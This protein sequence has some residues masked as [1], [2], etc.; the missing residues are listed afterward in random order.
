MRLCGRCLLLLVLVQCCSSDTAAR[1]ENEVRLARWRGGHAGGLAWIYH[2]GRIY[3]QTADE[4]KVDVVRFVG[5]QDTDGEELDEEGEDASA[6]ECFNSNSRIRMIVDAPCECCRLDACMSHSSTD[7]VG[8][9]LEETMQMAQVKIQKHIAQERAR[10]RQE[11][12]EEAARETEEAEGMAEA[13]HSLFKSLEADMGEVLLG[14]DYAKR[15]HH[16]KGKEDVKGGAG[17]RG[18]AEEGAAEGGGTRGA[19]LL[20]APAVRAKSRVKKEKNQ[21]AARKKA[22]PPPCPPRPPPTTTATSTPPPRQRGPKIARALDFFYIRVPL[23]AVPPSFA[24]R[25]T[26]KCLPLLPDLRVN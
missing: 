17:G 5:D 19:R 10:A 24:A 7:A 15:R 9:S 2:N 22:P 11:A 21:N 3:R 18:N 25:Q 8:M 16:S 23:P 4:D 13:E 14:F 1:L 26:K 20:D 12:D 6:T